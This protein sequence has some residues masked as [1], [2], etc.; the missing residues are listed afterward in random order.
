M[1]VLLSRLLANSAPSSCAFR[2]T[3]SLTFYQS[4]VDYLHTE[5]Q[6]LEKE[7]LDR[8]AARQMIRKILSSEEGQIV[9]SH[10]ALKESMP[11]ERITEDEVV[12]CLHRGFCSPKITF[13][14]GTWYF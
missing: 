2:P 12:S 13:E 7:P 14:R 6:M 11:D 1:N 3:K 9:F 8:V 5:V 10:H 4:A